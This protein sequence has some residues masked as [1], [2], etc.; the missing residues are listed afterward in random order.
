VGLRLVGSERMLR[1]WVRAARH[2]RGL[3]RVDLRHIRSARRAAAAL[4]DLSVALAGC[5]ARP[6]PVTALEGVEV[7]VSEGV[8]PAVLGILSPRI[9]VPRWLLEEA[10]Q[11]R[12]A[13]LAHESEHLRAHDGRLLLAAL[14]L[15]ALLPWNLPLRWLWR[16]LRLAI[17]VDCDARV[18]RRGL[19]PPMARICWRSRRA[20][21][22]RAFKSVRV[23]ARIL[24][25]RG[26]PA[27]PR[28]VLDAWNNH[29]YIRLREA[30]RERDNEMQEAR[31]SANCW[32]QHKSRTRCPSYRTTATVSPRRCCSP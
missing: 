18:V 10:A 8:G 25:R 11:R 5:A 20:R 15:V 24:A 28:T 31:E 27:G 23:R 13:V 29:S 16:R 1:P 3:R 17:E 30:L 12:S 26:R 21:R 9:V 7:A 2:A 19:Q 6:W 22:R 14:L 4:A 32:R